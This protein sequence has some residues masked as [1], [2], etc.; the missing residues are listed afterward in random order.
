MWIEILL[1]LTV[2]AVDYRNPYL[3]LPA[4]RVPNWYETTPSL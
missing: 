2:T 3:D 4:G 1:F